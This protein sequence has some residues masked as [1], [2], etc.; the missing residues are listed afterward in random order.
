MNK[1]KLAFACATLITLPLLGHAA[2]AQKE[3]SYILSTA[4]TGGTYYP[5]GVAVATLTKVKLAPK[6]KLSLSAITSAGSGDNLNLMLKNEAQ[7]GILQGLYGAWAWNGTGPFEKRGANKEFRSV[8]MLWKNV[9]H[10]TVN[11]S[12]M[13]S[14]Y[15]QDIS[16][17]YQKPLSIGKR[18]SGTEGSGRY[19]LGA[20]GLDADKFNNV[21][22]GYGASAGRMQDGRIEG[23]NTPG[24]VPVSAITQVLSSN[25][26]N[27]KV[28]NI[29]DESLEKINNDFPLWVRQVIPANTYPNQKEP[30][31]TIAQPN[32]LA[33]N[34]DLP[35]NDVYLITKAIYENLPFIK[36][37][38]SA[39]KVM[40]IESA[41]DGLIVPLHPG[42]VRYYREVGVTI[43]AHLIAE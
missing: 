28:L 9:E 11:K 5:V 41:I 16:A 18:N 19:I 38:H 6:E 36:S 39:T 31:N 8:T 23:M 2:N 7:F 30:I 40:S 37:I 42:A 34:A 3:R 32:F 15:L 17:L 25:G 14:N 4:S 43:P 21:H 26:E 10:F 29:S 1:F 27:L 20:L 24:G 22:M 33:V 12:A 35:E 13:K